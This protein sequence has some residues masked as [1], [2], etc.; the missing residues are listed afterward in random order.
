MT[1]P[2]RE[3]RYNRLSKA[4]YKK[5][6][7]RRPIREIS[8]QRLPSPIWLPNWRMTGKRMSGNSLR[9]LMCHPQ[10]FTPLSWERWS[11]QRSQPGGWKY[12]FPW[13][14]R[15]SNS[16][17]VR[18]P[19]RWRQRF[20]DSLRQ[21]SHSLTG[22]R[23]RRASWL[24]SFSFR[25]PPIRTEMGVREIA[26]QRTSLRRSGGNKSAAWSAWR[27]LAAILTKAKNTKCRNCNCFFYIAIF[28]KLSGH[29]S[30]IMKMNIFY[31][32][33]LQIS[34]S[35]YRDAHIMLPN[36]FFYLLLFCWPSILMAQYGLSLFIWRRFC[37]LF[38]SKGGHLQFKSATVQYCGQPNRLLSC[39]LKKVA[40]LRLRTFKI[41]LPQF[42]NSQQ[43]PANSATF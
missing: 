25:R 6:W 21:R 42:C 11:S 35:S 38:F 23:G 14:W 41:W 15:R 28:R 40:G 19:K 13:R 33:H 29:T 1:R 34:S 37:I 27:P 12:S 2:W 9:T 31:V 7:R 17:R 30:Y 24:T 4:K 22:G 32:C 5:R 26:W 10:R 16:G 3:W 20:F 18:Q 8:T 36:M 43:S 39:G